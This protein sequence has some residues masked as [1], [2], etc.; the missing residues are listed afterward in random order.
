MGIPLRLL[1][2]EDSEE[3]ALLVVHELRRHGYELIYERVETHAATNAALEKEGWD[4]IISD[5]SMPQFNGLD[6]LALVQKKALDIPFIIISGTIGEEIAVQAMKAGA[7]DYLIKGNLARLIPAIERELRETKIRQERRQAQEFIDY[8][9]YRDP[10]TALPNRTLLRE[11]LQ[12][13]I[14]L[15]QREQKTVALLLLDLDRFKEINDTL[16]H[17]RGDTVLQQVGARLKETVRDSDTVGRMGGDEFAVLLPLV[18]AADWDIVARKIM[19][20]FE[21]PFFIDGIPIAVETSLGVAL[22]P[23]HGDTVDV[24]IQ[25]ADIAMYVAKRHKS[26]F[27][28]YDATLDQHSPRRLALMGELRQAI[29][30]RQL[31][32]YYQPKI[33]LKTGQVAGVEG[34][35]R[36]HHAEHGF[37]PPDQFI[38]SA[39]QT[40]LITPLTGFVLEEAL[41][42]CCAWRRM[43]LDLCI[44]VNL[45]ARN[46]QNLQ[47]PWQ[48]ADL[49][50][51]RGLESCCLELEL[52]E[53]A[54]MM[55]PARA[56]EVLTRLHAMGIALTIDDFGV[57]Y[58]SLAYLQKLPI[59]TIKI[60]KSFVLGMMTNEND[61]VIVR[62]TI[63]LGRNL[64][65]KVVAEGVENQALF[66]ELVAFGCDLAQGYHI[67]RPM[68]AGELPAWLMQS[69]WG[70]SLPA[71]S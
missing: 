15:A 43:G 7:H 37:I 41:Q 28:L 25:R 64:G 19:Q 52:T 27:V 32:L 23:D 70:A 46:L 24:L 12:Q 65:L 67:S 66:D 4:L 2:V 71:V 48:V 53:S 35:L 18:D 49:L 22:H 38:A 20:A 61:R 8:M 69:S 51:A 40:G 33:D 31:K 36:W 63:E 55:N 57:G 39:E 47:L 44:A 9:A 11:Q 42:Q 14:K 1:L 3:D 29:D 60:D 10:L 54:I 45:S 68:P 62:S 21:P 26:G 59:G 5:Y 17:N 34:L 50:A 56:M 30:Q 16:G 13:A 58:S 6:A